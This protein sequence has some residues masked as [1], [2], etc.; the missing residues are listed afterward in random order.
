MGTVNEITADRPVKEAFDLPCRLR[1]SA[2]PSYFVTS[3]TTTSREET[4]LL[5]WGS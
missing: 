1:E 4:G 2:P 3:C 5:R